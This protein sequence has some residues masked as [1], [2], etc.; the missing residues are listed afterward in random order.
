M[1]ENDL[2]FLAVVLMMIFSSWSSS[3]AS[4]YPD[5]AFP[6]GR[7]GRIFLSASSFLMIATCLFVLLWRLSAVFFGKG[8]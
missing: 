7:Y 4:R 1:K 8:A 3:V 2:D 6:L 5:S